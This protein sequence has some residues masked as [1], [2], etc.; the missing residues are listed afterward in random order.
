[1]HCGW[2]TLHSAIEKS[3]AFH[4]VVVYIQA[5]FR[6]STIDGKQLLKVLLFT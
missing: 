4:Q 2:G 6:L 3:L 5:P 1:M